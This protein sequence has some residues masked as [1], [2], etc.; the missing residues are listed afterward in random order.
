MHQRLKPLTARQLRNLRFVVYF[1]QCFFNP[2]EENS[3][4][5]T[6]LDKES[7]EVARLTVV[8][9]EVQQLKVELD[10]LQAK[11]KNTSIELGKTQARNKTLEKHEQVRYPSSYYS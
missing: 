10:D 6:E 4:L 3:K 9:S 11:L 1:K 7:K 5:L 2:G 8:E